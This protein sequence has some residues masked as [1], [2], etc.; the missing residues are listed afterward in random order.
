MTKIEYGNSFMAHLREAHAK[1][2]APGKIDVY[3]ANGKYEVRLADGSR[4][5][6]RYKTRENDPR[7]MVTCNY[8]VNGEP[9]RRTGTSSK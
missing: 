7:V 4:K 9:Q 1:S 5:I 6:F 8:N 3:F 2:G